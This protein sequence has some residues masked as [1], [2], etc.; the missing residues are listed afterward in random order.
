[1]ATD[2]NVPPQGFAFSLG[3][4]APDGLS[5]DSKT[6]TLTWTPPTFQRSGT[7]PVTVIVTDNG[8]PPKSDATTFA[9]VVSDGRANGPPADTI[10]GLIAFW[11][12]N[13]FGHS[14]QALDLVHNFA[15]QLLGGATFTSDREGHTGQL[16]DRGLDFGTAATP[17]RSARVKDIG[18]L[19]RRAAAEDKMTVSFWL[20]WNT[21]IG[22]AGN[23]FWMVSPSSSS[24]ER[25]AAAHVPYADNSICNHSN[26]RVWRSAFRPRGDRNFGVARCFFSRVRTR[27]DHRQYRDPHR[28]G[29]CDPSCPSGG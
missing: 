4:G 28:C 23:V 16:G 8:A 27:Q 13:D 5:I 9:I 20:R 15:V 14:F 19:L 2:A 29:R 1:M 7:Y 11:D 12:F 6:G 18:A 22:G 3:F 26:Q 10:T 25:G 17:G 21:R 24:G